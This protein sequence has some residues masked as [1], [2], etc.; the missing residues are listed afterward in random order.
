MI[1]QTNRKKQKQT[2][3]HREDDGCQRGGVCGNRNKNLKSD[4]RKQGWVI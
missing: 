2:H 1:K 3:R 4:K